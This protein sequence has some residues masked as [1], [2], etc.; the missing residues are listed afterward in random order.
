M[1]KL[2]LLL[3]AVVFLGSMVFTHPNFYHHGYRYHQ[4]NCNFAVQY[5]APGYTGYIKND[6]KPLKNRSKDSL[7]KR[8]RRQNE[9]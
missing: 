6:V 1:K 9:R 2:L 3:T 5:Y 8:S 7:I 4:G